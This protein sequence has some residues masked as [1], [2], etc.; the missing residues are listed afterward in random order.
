MISTSGGDPTLFLYVLGSR[1][2]K[3]DQK[4]MSLCLLSTGL[5]SLVSCQ[6]TTLYYCLYK[7]SVKWEG[8]IMMIQPTF[9]SCGFIMDMKRYCTLS[10]DLD[11][12]KKSSH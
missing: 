8:A 9:H 5:S 3:E 10:G 12:T 6:C 4:K 11:L 2:V 1:K 7:F